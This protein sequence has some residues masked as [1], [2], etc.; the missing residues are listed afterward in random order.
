VELEAAST[1]AFLVKAELHSAAGEEDRALETLEHAVSLSPD[2]AE[3]HLRLGR[4]LESLG[5]LDEAEA[6]Y[7]RAIYLRP[8]FWPD[9]HW[10]A[11]LYSAQGRYDAAV[12]QYRR[13][14]ELA[15]LYDGG[16]NNLG[17]MF[18]FLDRNSEAIE[19]FEQSVE[20]EPEGNFYAFANLG[21]VYFAE[22][23]FADAAQMFERAV[24]IKADEHWLWGNLGY[25]Y[26]SGIDPGRAESPFRRAIKLAEEDLRRSTQENPQLLAVLA[27]YYAAVGDSE[28]GVALVE[29]AAAAGS[30]DPQVV[31]GITE[32]FEDL[33]ERDRALE[34]VRNAF[35]LGVAP[36]WFERRPSLRNLLADERYRRLAIEYT[37]LEIPTEK[38][39]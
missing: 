32:A 10:L 34:W 25:A 19:V 24:A 8:G 14:V 31:A 13:V 4:V 39:D 7:Q 28:R 26:Q 35:E 36:S 29:R 1:E 18:L 38:G 37:G 9:H 12:T 3:A 5:R 6:Q 17:T 30:K 27:G 33:G 16:Y 11:E 21:T 2:N 20:V 23:R 22:S 15:P